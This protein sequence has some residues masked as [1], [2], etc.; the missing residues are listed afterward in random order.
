MRD[1]RD[2]LRGSSRS[3]MSKEGFDL[4]SSSEAA[5]GSVAGDIAG[6]ASGAD[7]PAGVVSEVGWG[8]ATMRAKDRKSVV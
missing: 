1:V 8:S 4:P 3:S 2:S 7:P 6:E 5:R